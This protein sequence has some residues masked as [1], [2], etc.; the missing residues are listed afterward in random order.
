MSGDR[1]IYADV[2]NGYG[3]SSETSLKSFFYALSKRVIEINSNKEI[4]KSKYFRNTSATPSERLKASFISDILKAEEDFGFW[5]K[6]IWS[7]Q[8]PES[9]KITVCLRVSDNLSE[10]MKKEWSI[11]FNSLSNE[12]SPIER[13]LNNINLKGKYAQIKVIMET[14]SDELQ[15]I[16]S[17]INLVYSSKQ[18]QYFFTVKF[19]LENESDI[20]KGLLIG[21]ISQPINTEVVF[22]YSEKNSSN[23]EDYKIINPNSFFDIDDIENIKVG[24]KM[25]SHD[26]SLP[27]VEEFSLIYSGEKL[28]RSP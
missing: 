5:K 15:P 23:W 17:D 8:K 6:I 22:G 21:N 3:I 1:T 4:E 2:R 24:I 7:E 25:V 16:F 12:P 20:N 18:S 19:S 26:G 14:S 27:S 10:L 9:T 28:T 13:E 11:C